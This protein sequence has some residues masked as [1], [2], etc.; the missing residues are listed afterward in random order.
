[1]SMALQAN[2]DYVYVP[3]IDVNE[4]LMTGTITKACLVGTKKFLFVVPMEA[5]HAQGTFMGDTTKWTLDAANPRESVEKLLAQDD[6]TVEQLEE[7][8]K[9][10][11]EGDE[12]RRVFELGSVEKFQ[13]KTGWLSGGVHIQVPGEGKKA[14]NIRGKEHK[15]A[16][17]AFYE[18]QQ[19]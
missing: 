7:T 2:Q 19:R 12:Q 14:M 17:G 4:G 13:V 8:L 9:G 5:V 16:L 15:Q 1:M 6:L 18:G 3:T 11:L 10:L